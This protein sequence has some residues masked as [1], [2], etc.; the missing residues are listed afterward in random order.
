MRIDIG[1]EIRNSL[2]PLT[3]FVRFGIIFI[4][5]KTLNINRC[6]V[7]SFASYSNC[8][9]DLKENPNRKVQVVG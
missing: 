8:N 2:S 6:I 4:F 9:H 3:E 5:K 1:S 7:V